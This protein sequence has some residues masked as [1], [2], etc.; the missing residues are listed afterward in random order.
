[1]PFTTEAEL[2]LLAQIEDPAH[3]S[4]TLIARCIDDAHARILERLRAGIDIGNPDTALARGETLLAMAML[5]RALAAGD[6]ARQKQIVIG[7][8]R[9]GAGARFASLRAAADEAEAEA[10]E[11]LAD[12]LQAPPSHSVAMATDTSEL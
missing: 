12:S 4:A 6:A 3:A 1:M 8:Q 10:W 11:A 2:R 7:G 9:L 5:L